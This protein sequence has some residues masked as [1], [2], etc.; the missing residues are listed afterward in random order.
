MTPTDDIGNLQPAAGTGSGGPR[1]P[2]VEA[3]ARVAAPVL[4]RFPG[5]V[6]QAGTVAGEPVVTV[7]A[8]HYAEVARWLHDEG[9]FRFLSDLCGADWPHRQPRF[10]VIITLTNMDLGQR[11]RLVIGVADPGSPG[12]P[13]VSSVT[14]VWPAANWFE[15]ETYDMFGIVFEGHPG[16][17]RILMPDDWE[18]HPLRKDYS[19][20]KV[21]VEYK[22]LSPG[23]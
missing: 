10:D 8:G 11:L 23:R 21:P 13:V 15:R 16:L 17:K 3:A 9:G 6:A 22:N 5:A 20:G 19:I 4:K 1:D 12:T 18:G 7:G 14:G 2:R